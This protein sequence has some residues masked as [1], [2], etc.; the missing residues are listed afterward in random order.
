[1]IV[2]FLSF[3]E[4][5]QPWQWLI[6]SLVILSISIFLLGDSFLPLVAISIIFVAISDYFELKL[7]L[8]F[9]VFS[10]TLIFQMFLAPLLIN[11]KKILI[12][13]DVYDMIGHELRVVSINAGSD[14]SG[15][16]VAQNGKTWNVI[17]ENNESLEV[18][19]TYNCVKVEG[20]NLVIRKE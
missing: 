1:M 20:I 11:K 2:E 14:A 3:I 5:I 12:A 6:I 16:A 15:K 19:V 13:E 4:I 7:A 10:T 9:V 17:H 18:N 8:Q